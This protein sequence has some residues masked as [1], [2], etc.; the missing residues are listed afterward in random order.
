M[1]VVLMKAVTRI[2]SSAAALAG[3]GGRNLKKRTY[4]NEND[5]IIQISTEM[6]GNFQHE[7]LYECEIYCVI[8]CV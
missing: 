7:V 4:C 5:D 8:V 6:F 2:T 1:R 3:K